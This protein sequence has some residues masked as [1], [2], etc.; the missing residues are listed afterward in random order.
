L[1]CRVRGL[2]SGVGDAGDVQVAHT[3]PGGRTDADGESTS[4][5]A[6]AEAVPVQ[7]LVQHADDRS[8]VAMPRV[9]LQL[10]RRRRDLV[11]T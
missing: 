10:R 7:L 9:H 3:D 6:R 1:I 5:D 2:G 8:G 11:M 4:T